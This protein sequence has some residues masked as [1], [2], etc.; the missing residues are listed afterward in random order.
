MYLIGM[1]FSFGFYLGSPVGV[2]LEMPFLNGTLIGTDG[3]FAFLNIPARFLN[4]ALC[5]LSSLTSGIDGAGLCSTYAYM[6]GT[7][8][9]STSV[10]GFDWDAIFIWVLFWFTCWSFYWNYLLTGT[11]GGTVGFFYFLNIY[12]RILDATLCQ[13]PSLTSGLAGAG[14]CSV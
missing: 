6:I 9:C 1:Q 7:L 4:S 11:L 10:N 5:P 13:F 3:G 8:R 12:A 2:S 14:L